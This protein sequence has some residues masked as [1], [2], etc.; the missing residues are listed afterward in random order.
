MNEPFVIPV[1]YQNKT[2]NIPAQ[3]VANTYSYQIHVLIDESEIKFER[4]DEGKFRAIASIC[5]CCKPLLLRL[6]KFLPDV[7]IFCWQSANSN[8]YIL[9]RIAG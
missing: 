5:H 1:A 3:L 9:N 4:D 7:F 8:Q 2:I 6:T